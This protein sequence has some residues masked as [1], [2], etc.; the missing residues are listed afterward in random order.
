MNNNNPPLYIAARLT[1]ESGTFNNTAVNGNGEQDIE[2]MA[3]PS[4]NMVLRFYYFLNNEIHFIDKQVNT[5]NDDFQ[6]LNFTI[7]CGLF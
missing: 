1:T 7:D 5:N 4:W 6:N 3:K 2:L